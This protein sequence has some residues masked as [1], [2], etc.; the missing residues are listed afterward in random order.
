MIFQ[1]Y[2]HHLGTLVNP[3]INGISVDIQNLGCLRLALMIV[4]PCMHGPAQLCPV[5]LIISQK[6]Y[7][8]RMQ[9]MPQ[10]I[11]R[12]ILEYVIKHQIGEGI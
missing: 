4:K 5:F 1:C 2:P 6:L 7:Y 9:L 8:I 11:G 3:V 12:H 10:L